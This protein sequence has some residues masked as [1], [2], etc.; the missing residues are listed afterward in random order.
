VIRAGL[1]RALKLF[2][3]VAAATAA[4]SLAIGIANGS[5]VPRAISVGWYCSGAFLLA[6]GFIA[7]SRGPS[8]NADSGAW[9]PVTLRNRSLRWATRAEQ[10]DS[11]RVSVLLVVLALLLIFLGM[12]ADPRHPVF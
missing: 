2:V 10:E 6:L 8:R 1:A 9:S 3:G 4:V 11:L 5:S 12:A 7:S